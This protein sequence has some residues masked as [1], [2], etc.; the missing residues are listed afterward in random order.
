MKDRLRQNERTIERSLRQLA[1][2]EYDTV[3]SGY[4]QFMQ[5]AMNHL[6]EEHSASEHHVNEDNTLA[7]AIVH[8]GNVVMIYGHKGGEQVR[9]TTAPGYLL[10][11]I[12]TL[13]NTGWIGIL[14]SATK[15]WYNV[16]REMGYLT[17]TLSWA[18]DSFTKYFK[19]V[20]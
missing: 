9:W 15:G 3:L 4:V 18:K 20:K 10:R 2:R 6:I 1:K 11:I 19:P 5:A 16:E 8:D 17:D 13:P 7:W 12:P 14:L